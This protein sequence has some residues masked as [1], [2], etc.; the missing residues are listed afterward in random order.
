DARRQTRRVAELFPE[1][2]R[3]VPACSDT[4]AMTITSRE[5][6]AMASRRRPESRDIAV[7]SRLGKILI[8]EDEQDVAELIR[9]NLAR[10]GYDVRVALNGT[11]ALRQAR[12]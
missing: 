1:R 7:A 4:P 9:F 10:E 11:E 6:G 3:P 2:Q 8:V 12:E 5:S